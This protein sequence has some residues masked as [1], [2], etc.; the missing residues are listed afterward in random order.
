M[1]SIFSLANCHREFIVQKKLHYSLFKAHIKKV[2]IRIACAYFHFSSSPEFGGKIELPH[3]FG[4]R[5][6]VGRR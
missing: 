3:P 1:Q 2:E 5:L 6:Q 4:H